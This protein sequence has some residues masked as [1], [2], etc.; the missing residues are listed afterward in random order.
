MGSSTPQ[1]APAIRS[2][3]TA[4]NA[5]RGTEV[6]SR[7][8]I[9]LLVVLGLV[10]T[11]CGVGLLTGSAADA[12][13]TAPGTY[14]SLASARILDTGTGLGAPKTPVAAGGSVT[15]QVTGRGGVPASGAGAVALTLAAGSSTAAGTIVAYPAGTTRP[16][17]SAL[18]YSASH[19]SANLVVVALS[20]S[21]QVTLYNNSAGTVRLIGDV[22][23]YYLS[24][25]V[26]APGATKTVTGAR[27]L[28][29][30][31]GLGATHAPI[32]ANGTLT[33]QVSG[34]GN[35]AASGA[36][37]ALLQVTARNGTAAGTI[38]AYPGGGTRPTTTNL[39]YVTS[40]P[41]TDLVTVPVSST[42][43]VTLYNQSSGTVDVAADTAG[44]VLSGTATQEGAYH[45]ISAPARILDTGSTRVPANGTIQVQV[46]GQG[47]IPTS[48][49][50]TALLTLVA[51]SSSSNGSLTAWPSGPTAPATAELDYSTA[52]TGAAPVPVQPGPDGKISIHNSS[53]GTVRIIADT[54]GYYAGTVPAPTWHA[55]VAIDPT[56]GTPQDVS[57]P[58]TTFCAAV[59]QGGSVQLYN[60]T[61]WGAPQRID[62]GVDG[63]G[64]QVSPLSLVAV[65]CTSA[66][67][68]VATDADGYSL[69][70]NGSTWSGRTTTRLSPL[71]PEQL[72]CTSTTFCLGVET[73][74][75]SSRFNGSTWTQQPTITGNAGPVGITSMSCA[76]ATFCLATDAVNG[77]TYR[78]NGTSW[79]AVTGS[80]ASP[81]IVSC[82]STTFCI[83]AQGDT[84][85]RFNG[86]TWSAGSTVSGLDSPV[87]LDCVGSTFCV[88][89]DDHGSYSHYNGTSWTAAAAFD[90]DPNLGDNL[91]C[92]STTMCVDVNHTGQARRF[93]GASWAAAT[94][95]DPVRGGTTASV[96]CRSA[97]FCVAVDQGGFA[98][99]YDGTRWSAASSV[100]PGHAAQSVSCAST[101]F[102]VAVGSGGVASKFNGTSWSAPAVFDSA[103]PDTAAVS[104]ASTT[105]CVAVDS[106]GKASKFNGTSW[107]A[108]VT[109]G[110]SGTAL[111][112]VSCATASFCA[113]VESVSSTAFTYN[114]STWSSAHNFT[115]IGGLTGVSCTAATFCVA[116]DITGK[117]VRY[118]GTSWGAPT[119]VDSSGDNNRYVSCASTTSCA[120]VNESGTAALF[121]GTSWT[122]PTSIN[123]HP[124]QGARLVSLSCP[125]STYCT[126]LSND[127]VVITRY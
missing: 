101:T 124:N 6:A 61:T 19:T 87:S 104:C 54:Q 113:A 8:S 126:V 65:E 72:S 83:G 99:T 84:S 125:T 35:I 123:A 88:V 12:A 79:S 77:T 74:G 76:S 42:G 44:Y 38:T 39:N 78:Y 122:T 36:G 127:G 7:I 32:P 55:P 57:C 80:T 4:R 49:V 22:Q 114:G 23:G 5:S 112:A 121:N 116:S 71:E 48:G 30:S 106:S 111:A 81:V 97:V 24:G 100:M 107:A 117:V 118:N 92:A 43:Q 89:A 70:Y 82:T 37:T 51:G 85:Y 91:S 58:T 67:F 28:D 94:G 102:C 3:R 96:S 34:R 46:L 69:R 105:T 56:S 29:T 60:G 13:P 86:T 17:T 119:T 2:H 52:E 15:L 26:A 108:P 110:G 115:G 50:N 31:T 27:I 98:T 103:A 73:G 10:L 63:F 68:C 41:V 93:N 120:L 33:F 59:D 11:F 18:S 16:S 62:P 64:A 14:A 66:T 20:S 45:P 90:T 9:R 95:F 21:G 40:R 47:G 53:S 109:V 75:G 25:T 1:P